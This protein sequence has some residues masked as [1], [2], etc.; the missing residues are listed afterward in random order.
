MKGKIDH[1]TVVLSSF[2]SVIPSTSIF[3]PNI[4]Q[5]NML[6]DSKELAIYSKQKV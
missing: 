5:K 3:V 4:K 2:C 6:A 1:I